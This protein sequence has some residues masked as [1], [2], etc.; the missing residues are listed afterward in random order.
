MSTSKRRGNHE[1][2][3]PLQRS[4]GRWQVHVRYTDQYGLNKRTTVYG[5]TA[6][7]ARDK[8]SEVRKRLTEGL[9]ARDKRTTLETFTLEWITSALAASDRK[10]TTKTMYAG[11]ARVHIVGSHI[12]G[13]ALDKVR[14]M[15]VEGWIVG[16]RAKGLSESTVRSAYTI[17]RAIL[18]T[19]VRDGA[20][21]RNPAAAV[22]RPKVTAKESVFLTPEQ[23]R[24]LLDAAKSS[25]YA[26]LFSLLVNTGVR[27]GEALALR[28]S[29]IDFED[30]L[31]RVRGTL[32]RVDGDLIVTSTKTAKSKR[33]IPVSDGTDRLLKDIRKQQVRDQLKA[34]S[35]W[36]QSGYVFTT[37]DGRPCDPRNALRALKSAATKAGMTGVG[38]HTLRHSAATA[39]L[40]NGV[41]LKVVSEILGHASIV[42]TAD[43]YG[44]VS[45]DV[46]REALATLSK[47]LLA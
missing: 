1:G 47:S 16:L 41:P 36:H 23:V 33:S 20:L 27:R 9:P 32:A 43:I 30:K 37:E 17:L 5:R 31:L 24:A 39:M 14:P 7:D 29:D 22:K 40:T 45:P 26:P 46:S 35:Q 21:A 34:G 38:L 6:Q 13:L 12:G 15:H 8:A 18:D 3:N 44:H 42:I 4:D 2:S 19:A 25:R 28:W 10:S 11:V